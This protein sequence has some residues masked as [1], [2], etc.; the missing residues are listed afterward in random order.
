MRRRRRC[1]ARRWRVNR[2]RLQHIETGLTRWTKARRLVVIFVKARWAS[3]RVTSVSSTTLTSAPRLDDKP[4]KTRAPTW[5][6]TRGFATSPTSSESPTT[7]SG[8]ATTSNSK[9]IKTASTAKTVS[10]KSKTAK[11]ALSLRC[12]KT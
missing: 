9:T 6:V 3:K 7:T 1:S 2:R 11:T 5:S 8:A 4:G 12:M 10:G